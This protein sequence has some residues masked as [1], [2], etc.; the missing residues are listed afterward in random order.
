MAWQPTQY[1]NPQ[2]STTQLF[3]PREPPPPFAH[4]PSDAALTARITKLADYIARNGPQFLQ[5]IR[6]KQADNPDY[7]FLHNGP[8][9]DYYNWF[10]Y[11]TVHKMDP[12]VNPVQQPLYSTGHHPSGAQHVVGSIQQPLY[13]TSGAVRGGPRVW[14]LF[15]CWCTL[16]FVIVSCHDHHSLRP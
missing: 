5:L 16:S 13:A 4:P 10:L 9:C 8:G 12:K 6:T 3:D 7:G 1:V 11:C 15:F 2:E 14:V